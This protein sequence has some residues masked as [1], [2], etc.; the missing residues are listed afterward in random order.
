MGD[1]FMAYLHPD[2]VG[3]NFHKSSTE[4]IL[5]DR[6]HHIAQTGDMRCGAGA[7]DNGRNSIMRAFLAS[8]HEWLFMVDADMGF[9]PNALELLH[10]VADPVER[11]IVAGLC[12]AQREMSHDGRGGYR[13]NAKPTIFDRVDVPGEPI[14]T[15]RHHFPVNGVVRCDATGGAFLLI[16]RSVG[17]TIGNDWFTRLDEPRNPTP[18]GE[19]EMHQTHVSEDLSFFVRCMEH[20]IP[21]HVFTGVKTNHLKSV[22]VSETDFWQQFDPPPA[23]DPVDVIVPVLNRPQNVAPFMQ[24]LRASTGL[25]TAW[26]VCDRGDK[27]EQAEVAKYGGRVLRCDGSFAQKVNY[28][29]NKI[30]SSAPW[31]FLA[32]DDV[33]FRAGWLDHAQYVAATYDGKVIGTNDL[34]NARVTAGDHATHLLISREYINTTGASWDGPGVVCHEGYRHWFVDDEI[35]NAAQDRQVWQMALGSIVE[36]MHPMWGKG[37][38]DDVYELGASEA[39]SDKAKF[40]ARVAEYAA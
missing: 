23:T 1:T 38:N 29:Y 31:V 16:H 11:P 12:F 22:W 13:W 9:Q 21:C 28:A 4:L 30:N 15:Y 36:H 32:G 37:L 35:V 39:E 3:H 34:G 26:F 14:F 17:E 25:A 6:G 7:L 19:R 27:E 20:D 33:H 5:Y 8:G 10:Q 24:T 2:D 40:H 18:E